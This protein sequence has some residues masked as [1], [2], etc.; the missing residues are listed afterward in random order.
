MTDIWGEEQARAMRELA[1]ADHPAAKAERL[2]AKARARA[3]QREDATAAKREANRRRFPQTAAF[4]DGLAEAGVEAKVVHAAEGEHIAGSPLEIGAV[5]VW[6]RGV[7][8]ESGE[9]L[10]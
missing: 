4:M 10:E 7:S 5:V 3:H 1:G 8:R 9:F 2:E 6:E